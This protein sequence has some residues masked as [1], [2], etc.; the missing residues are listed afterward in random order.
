MERFNRHDLGATGGD[1]MCG[2]TENDATGRKATGHPKPWLAF[3]LSYLLGTGHQYAGRPDRGLAWAI[4]PWS[5]L[6]RGGLVTHELGTRV[7]HPDQ[8]DE[9]DARGG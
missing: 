1:V 2:S 6:R 4:G 3:L 7:P 9:T 8:R 5:A